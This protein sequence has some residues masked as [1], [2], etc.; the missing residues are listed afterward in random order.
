MWMRSSRD[1]LPM[2]YQKPNRSP[3][4]NLTNE[5]KLLANKEIQM[6]HQPMSTPIQTPQL[7][8]EAEEMFALRCSQPVMSQQEIVEQFEMNRRARFS[9]GSEENEVSNS[10]TS[11]D[12]FNERKE[13]S[14]PPV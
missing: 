1:R 2:T 4:R 14:I 6:Y 13:A 9:R 5:L 7:K 11:S 12:G 8:K 3:A 10:N